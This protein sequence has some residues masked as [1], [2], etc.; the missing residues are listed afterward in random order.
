MKKKLL[1]IGF[2]CSIILLIMVVLTSF[3]G[4]IKDIVLIATTISILLL[5]IGLKLFNYTYPNFLFEKTKSERWCKKLSREEK[6]LV[7]DAKK[8]IR[9]VDNKIV[10]SKFNVYKV[11][12]C[13]KSWCHYDSDTKEINIF[14]PFTFYLKVL[15]KDIFFHAVLHE[16]LHAQN[17]NKS[18]SVF[19]T[20]FMEGLNDLLTIWLI[21]N[22]SKKYDH[23][24]NKGI[25]GYPDEVNM[26]KDILQKAN[27][28]IRQV[29]LN[30]IYFQPDFFRSFVPEK[31][32]L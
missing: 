15:G 13:L 18:G 19:K 27:V 8:L 24:K 7:K 22:Y 25:I 29:F 12:F 16:I 31:Y 26:V 9:K 32:F 30:Y 6:K 10:L 14:I 17:G 1:K 5:V 20:N 2:Y 23:L 3:I 21:E 11:N 4:L 28:D